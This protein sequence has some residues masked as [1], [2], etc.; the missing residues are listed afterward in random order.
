[1]TSTSVSTRWFGVNVSLHTEI[2][3]RH[4]SAFNHLLPQD[5]KPYALEKGPSRDT[6]LGPQVTNASAHGPR[7]HSIK[8]R[9]SNTLALKLRM[10]IEQIYTSRVINSGKARNLIIPLVNEDTTRSQ[11]QS[12]RLQIRS[13]RRPR[14]NLSGRVV[15]AGDL[16][17]RPLKQ[18]DDRFKIIRPVFADHGYLFDAERRAQP[19]VFRVGLK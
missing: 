18:Y 1:V 6:D 17:H 3:E 9:T 12:P 10:D 14:G 4:A 16:T 8:Q 11:T 15:S 7:N 13:F 5:A 2:L 19:R